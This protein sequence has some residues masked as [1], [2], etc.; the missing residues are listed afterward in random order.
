M[1]LTA[2]RWRSDLFWYLDCLLRME[3]PGWEHVKKYFRK[4]MNSFALG[5][6]WML[7][8]ATTGFYFKLAVADEGL[9]WPNVVFYVLLAASFAGLL[10][11]YYKTWKN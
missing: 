11:Y 10:W 1:Y 7:S 2:I 3:E 9:H 8:A 4:I 5:L 6:L